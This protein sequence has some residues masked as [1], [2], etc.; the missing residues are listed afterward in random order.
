[1]HEKKYEEAAC[2]PIMSLDFG[3]RLPLTLPSCYLGQVT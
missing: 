3:V 1:M 2:F